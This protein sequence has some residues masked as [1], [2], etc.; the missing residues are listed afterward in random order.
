MDKS[1]LCFC[2][3]ITVG[4][5]IVYSS[6]LD[7]NLKMGNYYNINCNITNIITNFELK[8]ENNNFYTCNSCSTIYVKLN[9]FNNITNEFPAKYKMED[10]KYNCTFGRPSCNSK[11]SIS[12]K[13]K[14]NKKIYLKLLEYY[15]MINT[16]NT[17]NCFIDDDLQNVYL[18]EVN[19]QGVI[20]GF[21]ITV[22]LFVI[23]WCYCI[24]K[25][26]SIDN[27]K[28]VVDNKMYESDDM[29]ELDDM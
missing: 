28:K 26:Y 11:E 4:V 10:V 15:N 1:H 9:D 6:I 19:N 24:F 8:N 27:K 7:Y 25:A 5:I 29:N 3:I 21:G 22:G 23:G 18:T 20:I 16:N 12:K 17:V 13:I 14:E 2:T